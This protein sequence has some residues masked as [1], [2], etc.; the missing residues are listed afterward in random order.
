MRPFWIA[1]GFGLILMTV[2]G[3]KYSKKGFT[4]MPDM[5]FSP[6]VKAQKDAPGSMLTPPAGTIARGYRPYPFTKDQ[7]DQA[8]KALKNP[9][10]RTPAV[11]LKGQAL[12]NVY[13]IVCHGQFGEGDGPIIPKFPKPLSLQTERVRDFPD[14]RIFHVMTMGQNLM[15]SYAS[16]V[17]PEERWA[18]VHYVRELYRLKHPGSK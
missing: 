1:F 11:I 16:Q 17:E 8:A 18:V 12:F 7:P 5:A 10:S 6:A 4:Y 14:G 2:S 15:P 3:C 13:C 9:L